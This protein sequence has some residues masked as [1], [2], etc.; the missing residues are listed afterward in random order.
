MLPPGRAVSFRQTRSVDRRPI[1][2][3]SWQNTG[4]FEVGNDKHYFINPK[5]KGEALCLENR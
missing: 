2:R 1:F 4:R 3:I 5:M